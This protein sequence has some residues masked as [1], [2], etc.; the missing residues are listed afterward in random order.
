MKKHR[1][2][3]D[4]DAK[5]IDVKVFPNDHRKTNAALHMLY[6]KWAVRHLVEIDKAL[7]TF[8]DF[9]NMNMLGVTEALRNE[10]KKLTTE[11]AAYAEADDILQSIFKQQGNNE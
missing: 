7:K 11:N 10:R 5:D 1:V 9:S 8:Y 6:T 2:T 3:P 4:N